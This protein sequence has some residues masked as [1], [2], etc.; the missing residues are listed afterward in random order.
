LGALLGWWGSQLFEDFEDRDQVLLVLGEL[1]VGLLFKLLDP[2]LDLLEV[3]GRAADLDEGAHDLD[4]HRH[5][6]LAL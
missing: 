6:A 4:V 3:D 2:L 1:A 5:S